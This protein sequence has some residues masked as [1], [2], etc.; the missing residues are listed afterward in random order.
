MASL[1]ELAAL[2][3]I[4]MNLRTAF[5]GAAAA[6]L[7]CEEDEKEESEGSDGLCFAVAVGARRSLY[8]DEASSRVALL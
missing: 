1:A 4:R 3:A 5:P 8:M 6:G 2:P 7:R